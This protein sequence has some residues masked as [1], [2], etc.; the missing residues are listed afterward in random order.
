MVSTEAH[1]NHQHSLWFTFIRTFAMMKELL[2]F[3]MALYF[4][5]PWL[6]GL[7]ALLGLLGW[8]IGTSW[9]IMPAPGI[10]KYATYSVSLMILF[11]SLMAIAC[12]KLIAAQTLLREHESQF[13]LILYASPLQQFPFLFSRFVTV[14]AVSAVCMLV[15]N[16]VYTVGQ[17]FALTNAQP[18]MTLARFEVWR[19]VYPTVVFT[20]PNTLF[21]SAVVCS[22]AWWSRSNGAV[23]G[24]GVLLYITYML[25]LIVTDSPLM[26]RG[27]PIDPAI[28]DW[29]AL[30][31]PFGLSTL[32]HQTNTWSLE[33]RNTDLVSLSGTM[34][35]NRM[36]YIIAS[37]SVLLCAGASVRFTASSSI[38]G[39]RRKNIWQILPPPPERTAKE[40]YGKSIV[41]K[42]LQSSATIAQHYRTA[43]T[44]IAGL[45][46]RQTFSSVLFLLILVGGA[47][48]VSMELY[49]AID[50]GIR[51]PERYCTTGLV[52]NT[53]VSTFPNLCLLVLLL[54]S[55][56]MF[57]RSHSAGFSLIEDSTP[58]T[59]VMQFFAQWLAL[60]SLV[61]LFTGW[62]M[63]VGIVFQMLYRYPYIDWMLYLE[64]YGLCTVPLVLSAGLMLCVQSM[65]AN[66][67][68]VMLQSVIRR[69]SV[70][71]Y[72]ALACM[73]VVTLLTTQR[74]GNL[75]HP[76]IRFLS[77]FRGQYSDMSS[78]GG[79]VDVF[80]WKML[81]G[82]GIVSLVVLVTLIVMQQPNIQR[83]RTLRKPFVIAVLGM[84]MALVGVTGVYMANRLDIPDKHAEFAAQE[85]YERLYRKFQNTPQPVI[86]HV[87]ANIHLF[88][89]QSSYQVSGTYTLCN[90]SH[91]AIENIVISF[92]ETTQVHQATISAND[93]EY[94]ISPSVAMIHLSKPLRLLQTATMKFAF[95]YT[96]NRFQRHSPA[97]AIVENGAFTRLSRYFPQIGYQSA[98]EISDE[99]E[100]QRRHLGKA[101]ALLPL[102]AE[103]RKQDFVTV[104][105]TISTSIGQ[106]A[107]SVGEKIHQWRVGE[108]EFVRYATPVPIPFHFGVSSGRYAIQQAVHKGI[109]MEVYYH[110]SHYENV[111]HL[112]E[113]ARRT[114]DYCQTQFGAYPFKTIRFAEISSFASGF[115]ATAYPAT[116]FMTEHLA[117][118]SNIKGDKQQDV[119]NELAGH[120]LSHQ[121]WGGSQMMP[122]KREGAGF[123]TETL[124]MYTELMMLKAMYGAERMLP[125]VA[126][127]HRIYLKERG[128][129]PEQPLLRTQSENTHQHYS[130]GLVAMYALSERLGE[131]RVNQ[132]LK[133]F[134][135]KHNSTTAQYAPIATDL[136]QEFYAVSSP[137]DHTMIDDLF[138]RIVIHKFSIHKALAHQHGNHYTLHCVVSAEQMMENGH[139]KSVFKPFVGTIE[140]EILFSGGRKKIV[141][142]QAMPTPRFTAT[143][144]VDEQP[145][146][147]LVDPRLLYIRTTAEPIRLA[148]EYQVEHQGAR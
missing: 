117:F 16:V 42:P 129:A 136:L 115:N 139:G 145:R 3:E 78:W 94:Q 33:Q 148:V 46:L 89:E 52:A 141:T 54:Y 24:A 45:H 19:Y 133:A 68:P 142:V 113:N 85:Q 99:Q 146:E 12:T 122:D 137:S 124:A 50:K 102:E 2:T 41:G 75:T 110:P 101:T 95:S 73:L 38:H 34:L 32:F 144:V 86:T 44:S 116:I 84:L 1:Y 103:R 25:V 114:L 125:T 26:S 31:D 69:L 147:V 134:L 11:M 77:P 27:M 58:T 64:V 81:L 132:A 22:V 39:A 140:L 123:L 90:T 60:S 91:Q 108:R 88:P 118:H 97:N 40:H 87:Q 105:M 55:N 51:L 106:T 10:S 121:W 65:M 128:Y 107:I 17:A 67:L 71:K 13:S 48:Y 82:A 131:H 100:R 92:D 4:K 62:M 8:S 47:F 79:S 53:I 96:W 112:L 143:I 23:Y 6:Y 80:A 56:E 98:S 127:H 5:K 57:W 36:L 29:S 111:Q 66:L 126:M 119:I 21:C 59:N 37:V 135:K 7:L 15:V 72:A 30:L 104:D 49:G 93:T 61:V 14:F 109:T 43:L 63:V 70:N 76:L 74:L 28:L 138:T 18:S 130:K 120:E 9:S 20:L 83:A 35:I